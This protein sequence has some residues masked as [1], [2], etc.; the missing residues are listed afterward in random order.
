MRKQLTPLSELRVDSDFANSLSC[1]Y[2]VDPAGWAKV[3]IIYGEQLLKKAQLKGWAHQS[4][5]AHLWVGKVGSLRV[6]RVGQWVFYPLLGQVFP[7]YMETK[8]GKDLG[9]QWQSTPRYYVKNI[10]TQGV[11]MCVV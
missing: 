11:G 1:F 3:F 9:A 5:Q 4:G 7:L 8:M 6:A 2:G 10:R